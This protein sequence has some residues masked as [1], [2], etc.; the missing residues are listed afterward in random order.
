MQITQG[1]IIKSRRIVLYAPEGIGKST[2]ASHFPDPVFIDTEGSTNSMDVKRLPAPQS[3]QM[4][5][6]EIDYIRRTPD[7]CQTLVIDTA[8]WAER[9]CCMELCA[10]RQINGIEDIPYGKGWVYVSE[11]FGKMLDK[12]SDVCNSGVNVVVTAHAQ[13]RKF[14]QPDEM[15]AYD[16]WELKLGNRTRPLLKEWADA[17][18]FANYKTFV[19]NVD[20]QGAAKGKNKAQGGERVMYTTHHPCWDAKNR[21]G[22]PDELPFRYESIAHIIPSNG[23]ISRSTCDAVDN[24]P[25]REKPPETPLERATSDSGTS[26]NDFRDLPDN[27]AQLMIANGVTPQE[28]VYVVAQKGYF[29]PDTPLCNYPKDFIDGVLVGAWEQVFSAIMTNRADMP[30]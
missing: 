7:V 15:G 26:D 8:D 30:F 12:L 5:M 29:P 13:M 22:L 10:K 17:L 27:L 16:R 18:L 4:L 2:F 6:D 21:D 25:E 1:K 19:V 24:T 3:W 20:Q 28:L 14:E 23:S 9:L 11:A